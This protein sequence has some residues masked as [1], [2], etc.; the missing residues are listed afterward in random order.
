[1]EWT[2]GRECNSG[3]DTTRQNA[4]A[5]RNVLIGV[6]QGPTTAELSSIPTIDVGLWTMNTRQYCTVAVH[7]LIWISNHSKAYSSVP[8][9]RTV[10]E[11]HILSSC[12]HR[13]HHDKAHIPAHPP[14]W[15]SLVLGWLPHWYSSL[16]S[17]LILQCSDNDCWSGPEEVTNSGTACVG[18]HR[19][20]S[21]SCHAYT[22]VNE[23]MSSHHKLHVTTRDKQQI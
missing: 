8:G 13:A 15:L 21:N 17:W 10:Y 22:R 6:C 12:I 23:K 11:T 7:H 1:M 5:H 4:R 3:Q 19:I 14:L 2:Q 18:G 16:H 20:V 9:I